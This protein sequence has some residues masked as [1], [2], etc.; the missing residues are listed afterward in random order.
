MYIYSL[1]ILLEL[2]NLQEYSSTLEQKREFVGD[3]ALV[4]DE[5]APVKE[6]VS[7]QELILYIYSLL[8]LLE[9]S[10]LWKS[11]STLDQKREFVRYLAQANDG[12]AQEPVKEEVSLI[13]N[14]YISF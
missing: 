6:K 12:K 1:L 5:K 8:F 13:R 7:L 11:S 4:N 14:I 3:F 9:L 10:N 2:S